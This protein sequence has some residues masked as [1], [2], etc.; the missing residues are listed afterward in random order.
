MAGA[1]PETVVNNETGL[2]FSV[3]NSEML[4]KQIK[5]LYNDEELIRILGNNAELHIKELTNPYKYY[6]SLQNILPILQQKEQLV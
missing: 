3:G 6:Q 5:V 2:L 4:A 1:I